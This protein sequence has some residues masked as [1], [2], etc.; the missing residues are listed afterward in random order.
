[1]YRSCIF[2]AAPLGANE[3]VEAFPVGRTV[4]FD[5]AR[6]RLWAV[7]PK[8]A[9]WNL[10]PLEERWEA[11]EQGERLFRDARLRAQSEN[12]GLARLRDGTRLIR[13]GHAQPGEL[14]V[15]R[16]GQGLL[17]RRQRLVVS[18]GTAAVLG[19]GGLLAV[20]GVVGG[21]IGA[22]FLAGIG[23]V[24]SSFVE[25][26]LDGERKTRVIH[27][28]QPGETPH[29][30]PLEVKGRHLIGAKL[31]RPAEG[32]GIAVALPAAVPAGAPPLVIQGAAGR[33]LLSRAM[34]HVNRHGG[35]KDWLES[36]I[37]RI[38]AHGT[39]DEFLRDAAEREKLLLP[40]GDPSINPVDRLALE[41]AV[42]EDAERRAMEGELAGLEVMWREAEEIA[43]LADRL[44]DG[45]A[46]P[47]RIGGAAGDGAF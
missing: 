21:V 39:A 23:Y 33:R 41:M 30:R 37:D 5:G 18:A 45:D 13:V 35:K 9:R 25:D 20:A 12:V 44:P 19:G 36:A 46:D 15:W 16:Y 47:P 14:A 7:C 27:R 32:G 2:C 10:A 31:T 43:A 28:L 17:R 40:F 24:A 3:S 8:C 26:M 1:M 4:A 6:G 22:A 34:V 38:G 11:I 42:H 29:G